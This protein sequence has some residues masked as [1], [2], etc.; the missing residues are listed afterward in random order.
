MSELLGIGRMAALSGLSVSA[1]RFYDA[2]G[3]LTP[4]EVDQHSGYRRYRTDQV[5]LARLV[6]QLRRVGTPLAELRE[7]VRAPAS[8]GPLLD[9]QL[10]RLE[11]QLAE[12]R[13]SLSIARSLLTMEIPPMV[14]MHVPTDELVAALASVSFAAGLDPQLPVL[15][16]VLFDLTD[17]GLRLV[18]TDRCRLAHTV[19][20]VSEQAGGPARVVVPVPLIERV[21]ACFDG[22]GGTSVIDAVDGEVGFTAG[23]RRV[24]GS[25]LDGD[26]PHYRRFAELRPNERV[27]VDVAGLRS[28]VAAGPTRTRPH[29]NG[30]RSYQ[31]TVLSVSATGVTVADWQ[32]EPAGDGLPVGVNQ[33]FLLQALAAGRRDQ[34]VLEL[35]GPV[36]PLVLRDPDRA[37]AFSVLMPVRLD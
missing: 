13:H 2:A 15:G 22:V 23:G 29:A 36:A 11:G 33:E 14:S 12:A 21:L 30:T 24:S 8:A 34:L 25:Q 37:D 16:G 17:A 20:P 6:A 27:A 18:A 4:A 35:D 1:L 10:A 9:R 32:R 26:F 5:R 3:V 28:A 7:V 19:V 31:L